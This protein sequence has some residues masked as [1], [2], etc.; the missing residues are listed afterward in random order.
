MKGQAAALAEQLWMT[1]RAKEDGQYQYS[2]GDK[3]KPV[4]TLTGQAFSRPDLATYPVGG[5]PSKERRS[6][7]PLF[8]EWLMGWPP[9]WTLLAWT[10]LGCSGTELCHFK[11]RMRSALSAIAL[12]AEAPPVQLALFG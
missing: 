10:D 11:Q 7:N 12:P 2:R 6:L 8:V 1:P 4:A 3:A 9:G 5:I